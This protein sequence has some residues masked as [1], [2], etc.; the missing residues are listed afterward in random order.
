MARAR[1]TMYCL[2]L[3]TALVVLL[4][5][6]GALMYAAMWHLIRDDTAQLAGRTVQ[7]PHHWFS[8]AGGDALYIRKIAPTGVLDP[9]DVSTIM[10]SPVSRGP[11]PTDEEWRR[12]LIRRL[13]GD[14]HVITR[15]V[16]PRIGGQQ[17][18]CVEWTDWENNSIKKVGCNVEGRLVAI[19]YYHNEASYSTFL[20]ILE[21][22]E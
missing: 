13:E 6:C 21:Q 19:F 14:K 17:V 3:G 7:V 9:F 11:V 2:S 12:D 20:N 8:W 18:Y 15:K 10:L 16:T 1:L 22:V 4:T 5:Y